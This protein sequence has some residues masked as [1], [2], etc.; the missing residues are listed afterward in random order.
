MQRRMLLSMAFVLTAVLRPSWASDAVYQLALPP[1]QGKGP[2]V[3]VISGQTGPANYE[4]VAKDL[5]AAGYYTVLVDGNDMFVSGGAGEGRLRS[6]IDK[7]LQSPSAVSG[8]AAV[9]GFSLGGG[10]TLSY[11][12]RMADLVGVVVASYPL[13]R[14][15]TDPRGFVAKI[16]VPTLVMAGGQDTY[17]N[18]CVID[19]ARQ[20]AESAKAIE[21]HAPF[22][23]VEYPDAGH[24]WNIRSSREWRG[25]IAA[26]S[27]RRTIEFLQQH[28]AAT[29]G[30]PSR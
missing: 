23:L 13:T 22:V 20:L 15:I 30:S 11:A 10:A 2:L 1:P 5:A 18:C 25:D 8:K 19:T 28:G 4:H 27:L 12:A 6:V 16:K 26:D 29:E 21:G 9:V 14:F 24:G 7:A 17:K 3:V